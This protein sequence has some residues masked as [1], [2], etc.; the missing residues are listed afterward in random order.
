MNAPCEDIRTLFESFLDGGLSK[1]ERIRVKKHLKA[2]PACRSELEREREVVDLLSALPEV[3]CP[4][5]IVQKIEEETFGREKKK[6]HIK[7]WVF[8]GQRLRWG[9]LSVGVAVVAVIILLVV[10]PLGDR[11]QTNQVQYS[12]EEVEKAKDEA[13]WSLAYLAR[14]VSETERNVVED[15]L[16][17]DVPST[18]RKSIQKTIPIFGG[19]QQ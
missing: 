6:S 14:V 3:K 16:L 17:K 7:R 11:N 8:G 9:T 4:E 15:V 1:R 2:C 12:Q 18:V 5:G 19:N 10:Q 13:K